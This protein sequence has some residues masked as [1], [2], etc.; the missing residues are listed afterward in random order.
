MTGAERVLEPGIG[1]LDD[2]ADAVS[3]GSGVGM[4]RA[5]A[6]RFRACLR[7][8]SR[9]GLVAMIG[10]LADRVYLARITGTVHEVVEV[11]D[12]GVV[13]GSRGE[14]GTE[15]DPAVCLARSPG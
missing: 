15:R 5:R 9:R 6:L 1:P 3:E 11:R 2:R 13:Q 10:T 12:P 7:A 8:L 14:G 4:G